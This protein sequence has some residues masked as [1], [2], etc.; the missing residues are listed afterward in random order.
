VGLDPFVMLSRAGLH[1]SAL[2]DPE[3]WIAAS[4]ILALLDDCA[5]LSGRDDFGVLLGE[6]R[7]FG[8]LGPV[9]LLLKH[10]STLRET[11]MAMIEYQRLLN[12]L[13]HVRLREE[14]RTGVLE[15]NLIPGL[16]SSQGICLLATIAYRVLVQGTGI[17]WQPDCIHFR[18]SAPEG[19]AT[20]RRVFGCPLEFDGGFDGMSFAAECLDL[21]NA[22]A[23][24]ELAKHARRLLQLL[25]GIRRYETVSDQARSTIPFLIANGQVNA[26]DVANCLGVPV[27]TLQRKLVSEGH[28]F[29][30]L[31]NETRRELAV[32]YLS[33][34][35][36]SITAVAQLTGYS[37]L[38]SF[39]RWFVSE[40][41][42]S[43]GRWRRLMR[44]R[45]EMFIEPVAD[46]RAAIG[47]RMLE[48]SDAVD[49]LS[50]E[51]GERGPSAVR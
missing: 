12:E 32:R 23:D 5:R 24:P 19:I 18:H 4:R 22:C 2:N 36:H 39:T 3:N 16:R 14:G 11:I 31:L 47:K 8:S 17:N 13:L 50:P 33:N 27:R 21:K 6:C 15:W 37:A 28:S 38:S 30:D 34:S 43:P 45:D 35:N 42:M 20:F 26:L 7:T 10:E 48:L 29:S 1:P 40:F 46:Q 44:R 9:S 25:P 51:T 41:G 49:A